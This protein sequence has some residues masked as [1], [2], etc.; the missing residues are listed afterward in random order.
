MHPVAVAPGVGFGRLCRIW[1]AVVPQ[2]VVKIRGLTREAVV[3][4]FCVRT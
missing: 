2:E 4:V 3:F 1:G